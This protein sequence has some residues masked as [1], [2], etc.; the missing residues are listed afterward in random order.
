MCN[1]YHPAR[2]RPADWDTWLQGPHEGVQ[3][4]IRLTAIVKTPTRGQT[5]HRSLFRE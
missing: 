2:R 3:A 4:Q 1:R 5:T